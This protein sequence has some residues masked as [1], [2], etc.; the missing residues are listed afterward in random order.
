MNKDDVKFC[1]YCGNPLNQTS[2]INIQK[3]NK[4]I[5][6]LTM[7]IVV[8][9]VVIL[10]LV[11]MIVL[12][13]KDNN[14]SR[15]EQA[16]ITEKMKESDKIEIENIEKSGQ[17]NNIIIKVENTTSTLSTND[18]HNIEKEIYDINEET[19]I[20][21][22]INDYCNKLCTAINEGDYS[23]VSE[24]ILIG[25]PLEEMQK[26]LVSNLHDNGIK[27]EFINANVSKISWDTNK[28]SCI[29]YVTEQEII[30]NN[31]NSQKK[32]FDWKYSAIKKDGLWKLINI[33]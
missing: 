19:Q 24:C 21:N 3:K 31:G 20:E 13:K 5:I 7:I 11:Y 8:L 30:N 4:Y 25:S 28:Q 22:L 9:I 17:S 32:S 1:E 23:I 18:K 12:N 10:S 29:I 6:I 2:T 16:T 15:I 26:S 33:Q 27:E 14:T